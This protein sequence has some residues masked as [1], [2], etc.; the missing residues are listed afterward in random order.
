M[1]KQTLNNEV[2]QLP[3][4]MQST[5]KWFASVVTTRLTENDNIQPYTVNGTLIAEEA[6]RYITPSSTLKPHQR[7]QI[8]NQQ[9]WWRL[10]NTLHTNFPLVTRLF[11]CHTFNEKIGIPYLLKYPPDHWSL[12]LLGARL[13]KWTSE[14]YQEPDRP[15][16]LNAASLDWT[17]MA[18][19]IAPQSPYPDLAKLVK[20]NSEKLLSQTFYLQP[21]INLF[22]WEYD[23][24]TFRTNFLKQG[25]DYWIEHRFPDLPKGKTYFFILYR[26]L[27]NHLAWR[28]IS[29]EEYL[30]LELFK[31][32]TNINAACEY[33]ESQESSVYDYVAE[34]LQK[35]LQEWAQAG[36]LTLVSQ[37]ESSAI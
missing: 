23:L 18:S 11:G 28:E 5:Q 3:R 27:Q 6:A 24:L 33:I 9:Y 12:N 30:L 22:T 34:H 14:C 7:M 26:N 1:N 31:A 16:V 29:R 19:F 21:H 15:L 13:P 10:L 36:W 4:K 25:V 2:E 37:P 17:F 8:Y 20:E 35:W 32:G